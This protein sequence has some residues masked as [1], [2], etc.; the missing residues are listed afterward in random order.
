MHDYSWIAKIG[1]ALTQPSVI[2]MLILTMCE[3]IFL[4][5]LFMR[6]Q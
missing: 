6:E 1:E 5:Y 3:I 4:I 2:F